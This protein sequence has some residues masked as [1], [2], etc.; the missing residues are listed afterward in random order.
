MTCSQGAHTGRKHLRRRYHHAASPWACRPLRAWS[1]AP[2]A[3][4]LCQAASGWSRCTRGCCRSNRGSWAR[5]AP[6]ACQSR[7]SRI[8][9]DKKRGSRG[10]A[11]ERGQERGESGDV[12]EVQRTHQSS[13]AIYWNHHQAC[14]GSTRAADTPEWWASRHCNGNAIWIQLTVISAPFGKLPSPPPRPPTPPESH[15]GKKKEEMKEQKSNEKRSKN[16]LSWLRKVHGL[17]F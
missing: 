2:V 12:E 4:C 10:G 14:G 1:R 13:G 8:R 9:L 6:L 17:T 16:F 15:Q 3:G 5:A 11:G 7:T